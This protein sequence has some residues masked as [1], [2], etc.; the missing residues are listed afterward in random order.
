MTVITHLNAS[1]RFK[2]V[3]GERAEVANSRFHPESVIYLCRYCAAVLARSLLDD[4]L[5][6]E[7]E[8]TRAKTSP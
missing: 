1:G 3:C 7:E 2:C 5:T 8:T 4:M 6:L